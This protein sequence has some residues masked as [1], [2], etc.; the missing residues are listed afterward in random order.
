MRPVSCFRVA[1]PRGRT[2]GD[3]ICVTEDHLPFRW[4]CGTR[5]ALYSLKQAIRRRATLPFSSDLP[6]VHYLYCHLPCCHMH[7]LHFDLLHYHLTVVLVLSR[8]SRPEPLT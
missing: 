2:H 4:D 3:R 6:D 8:R 5:P 7:L 1:R